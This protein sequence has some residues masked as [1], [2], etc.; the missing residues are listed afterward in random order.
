V[1]SRFRNANPNGKIAANPKP[2]LTSHLAGI[3]LLSVNDAEYRELRMGKGS[4]ADVRERINVG[5]L[6]HTQGRRGLTI[7]NR[8]RRLLHIP[9]YQLDFKDP[10]GAGDATFAAAAL[11]LLV[12]E[13]QEV[14]GT[15]A[16]T[17]GAAKVAKNGTHPVSVRDFATLMGLRT[18]TRVTE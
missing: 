16:N 4:I 18:S 3:D 13:D 7:V 8:A 17:A 5:Y 14:I 2:I 12:T 10:V 9:A 11:A 15:L 6:L 1:V